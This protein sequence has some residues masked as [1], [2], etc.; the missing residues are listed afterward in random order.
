VGK[1]TRIYGAGS[2]SG[3]VQMLSRDG[4]SKAIYSRLSN[5]EWLICRVINKLVMVCTPYILYAVA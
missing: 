5:M 1:D 3:A 2:A 4:L